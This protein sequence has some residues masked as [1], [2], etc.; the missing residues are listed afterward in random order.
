MAKTVVSTISGLKERVGL[1]LGTSEWVEVSQKQ[2]DAFAEATGDHQWIHVDVDRAR[3]ESPFKTPIAHGY[4]T[5]ALGPV[6][7]PSLLHVEG[8][9]QI[10]NYGIDKM[11]LPAPVP[12]GSRVRLSASIKSVRDLPSGAAR[13]AFA[14][15][16]EIEGGSK[17]AC[18]G[19]AVFVYF[20]ETVEA[21]PAQRSDDAQ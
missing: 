11:R 18:T 6:L 14:L 19:D 5:I 17:P 15:T 10:V 3:E 1:D 9:G 21:P 7:L 20:P 2:I 4:L 13:V 8:V 12:A 16:F